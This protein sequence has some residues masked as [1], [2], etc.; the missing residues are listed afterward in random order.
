M[1]NIKKQFVVAV[2]GVLAAFFF[3]LE[4]ALAAPD[5]EM[6]CI[7]R[8]PGQMKFV[9][10]NQLDRQ[11]IAEAVSAQRLQG[12]KVIDPCLTGQVRNIP[13]SVYAKLAE[14]HPEKFQPVE[15]QS[16]TSPTETVTTGGAALGI[17][18]QYHFVDPRATI[19]PGFLPFFGAINITN[20]GRVYGIVVTDDD[21]FTPHIAVFERGIVAILQLQEMDGL[22]IPFTVNNVGTVGGGSLLNLESFMGQAA[23]F[24]G[25]E[26]QLI[27]RLPG[28]I[29]SFVVK[30][31]D[32]GMALIAS[33]DEN[34]NVTFALYN[35][36]QVT[37]LDFGPDIPFV[38]FL[39]GMN[40]QGI[41]AGT[42]F[43]DSLG[44]RGF[45]FDPN[46]NQ[47]ALLEPLP[48]EPHAWAM[49]IN[50]RGDILGYSFAFSSTE[51]IG[52]WDAKGKFHTYFVEG[53]PEFPTISNNLVFNDNNLIVISQVSNPP[54]ERRRIY[55]VPK[56]GMRLNLDDFVADVPVGHDPYF[57]GA[58]NNHGSMIGLTVTP[59]ID[60][61]DFLLERTG[62]G[63]K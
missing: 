44:Y 6:G 7:L 54:S 30:I 35:G 11:T 16:T 1:K 55:L 49:G 43:I 4:I 18:P 33:F 36:K 46:T 42:T 61:Y 48:T 32:S 10:G 19:P 31:N 50:D 2:G 3:P 21:T 59:E 25:N 60:I 40:N 12:A 51:R 62:L 41:I 28:E 20:D 63:D 9:R 53:T 24:R 17:A 47:T 45:R 23:L 22:F 57:V 52:V 13:A 29:D 5:N 8:Q 38:S 39:S 34:F 27:P 56:P 37:P 15:S 26:V 58:V 14:K